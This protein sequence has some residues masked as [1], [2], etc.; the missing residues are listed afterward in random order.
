LSGF[1]RNRLELNQASTS[2]RQREKRSTVAVASS[3]D[4]LV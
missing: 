4:V 1:S 3:T 2:S